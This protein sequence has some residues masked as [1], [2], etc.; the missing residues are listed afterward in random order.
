MNNL[1]Y[2]NTNNPCIWSIVISLC[3][4]FFPSTSNFIPFCIIQGM[5][6]VSFIG[7]GNLLSHKR[8]HWTLMFVLIVCWIFAIKYESIDIALCKYSFFPL[9]FLGAWG[10]TMLLYYFSKAFGRIF[11][12]IC[13]RSIGKH[14]LT[15]LCIY[16]IFSYTGIGRI[17]TE[18]FDS[19]LTHNIE[20]WIS[21]FL[22]LGIIATSFIVTKIP[23]VNKVY[24]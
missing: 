14:S 19:F 18:L 6:A 4:S 17:V 10:G 7:I 12:C 23:F 9:C 13:L 21:I 3:I 5:C 20:L 24:P 2:R 16:T 22:A 11:Q 8:L 1:G 15:I